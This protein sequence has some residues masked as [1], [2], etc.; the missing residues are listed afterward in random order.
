[1][2]SRKLLDMIK[3]AE[4][5]DRIAR[6][7][8]INN[9]EASVASH[10]KDFFMD[11]CLASSRCTLDTES[12]GTNSLPVLIESQPCASDTIPPHNFFTSI[13]VQVLGNI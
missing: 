12:R 9:G 10:P 5:C 6:F 4:G 2:G 3:I 8:H 13:V 1:M 7:P 11:C